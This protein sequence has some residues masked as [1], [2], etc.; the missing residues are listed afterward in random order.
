M[1][2]LQRINGNVLKYFAN[3]ERMVS[4]KGCLITKV[5]RANVESN[6]GEGNPRE[7]KELLIGRGLSVRERM[8]LG[9]YRETQGRII[10]RSRWKV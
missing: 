9:R 7:V 2:A 6:R 4:R 3:V 8:V 5:Y 10:E 1:S